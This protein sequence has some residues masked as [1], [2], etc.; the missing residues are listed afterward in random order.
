MGIIRGYGHSLSGEFCT[1][2]IDGFQAVQ[3]KK[4]PCISCCQVPYV[5][6]KIWRLQSC[7]RLQLKGSSVL[8]STLL[9]S[10]V[11]FMFKTHCMYVYFIVSYGIFC[12]QPVIPK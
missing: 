12:G 10:L 7:A 6:N 5:L 4:N 11:F 3:K 9:C 1:N 2:N 8:F